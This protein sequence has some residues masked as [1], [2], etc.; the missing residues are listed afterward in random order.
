MRQPNKPLACDTHGT[1][2]AW[3]M[4]CDHV[5]KDISLAAHVTWQA[6]LCAVCLENTQVAG[7]QPARSDAWQTTIELWRPTC[8]K[9]IALWGIER[10]DET[11]PR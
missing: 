3:S 9:C 4:T 2:F 7:D 1:V 6:I 8:D 5:R 11:P 10:D